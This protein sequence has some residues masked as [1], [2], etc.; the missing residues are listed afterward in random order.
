M[1]DPYIISLQTI[2]KPD[3]NKWV[4]EHLAAETSMEA[5]DVKL[6]E[7]ACRIESDLE[8]LGATGIEDKLQERVPET[9]YSLRKAGIKVWVLTGDKQETAIQVAYSSQLFDPEQELI[10][11][12]ANN[13][14]RILMVCMLVKNCSR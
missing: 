8:L 2:S 14:V 5:R 6:M 9:I 10:V 1:F 7:S 4:R 11:M 12:N 13:M 3:Y